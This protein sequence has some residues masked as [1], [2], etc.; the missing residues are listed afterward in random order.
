MTGIRT[1]SHVEAEFEPNKRSASSFRGGQNGP[2][3]DWHGIGC[4][5]IFMTIISGV[6]STLCIPNFFQSWNEIFDLD[7]ECGLALQKGNEMA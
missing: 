1:K 2:D 7:Q 6:D 4:I 5:R 3:L